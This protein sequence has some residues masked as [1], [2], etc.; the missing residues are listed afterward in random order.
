MHERLIKT[1]RREALWRVSEESCEIERLPGYGHG[2]G[3]RARA[4]RVERYI[5]RT[6]DLPSYR[7]AIAETLNSPLSNCE[8]GDT[9]S[10]RT[11]DYVPTGRIM[12]DN[13]MPKVEAVLFEYRL[14]DARDI[15]KLKEPR[16]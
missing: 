3:G 7:V 1:M 16:P 12:Y 11:I 13:S 9:L 6:E 14:K 4:W 15:A 10:T 8:P 2:F 5:W